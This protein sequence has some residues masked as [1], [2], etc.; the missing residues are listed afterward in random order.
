MISYR[1]YKEMNTPGAATPATGAAAPATAAPATGGF[2][3]AR[4]FSQG[5]RAL[6]AMNPR[7]MAFASNFANVLAQVDNER[8]GYAKRLITSMMSKLEEPNPMLKNK[9]LQT[10]KFLPDEE[11]QA[12]V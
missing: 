10:V 1:E 7:I 5:K 3:I 9:L 12:N 6:G 11:P 4:T 2:D 8:P